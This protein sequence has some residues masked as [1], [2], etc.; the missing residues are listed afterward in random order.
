MIILLLASA[1]TVELMTFPL[2]DILVTEDDYFLKFYANPTVEEAYAEVIPW[3][4]ERGA[5][6]IPEVDSPSKE[7]TI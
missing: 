3:L 6:D 4:Y 7:D 5:L 1:L 2:S